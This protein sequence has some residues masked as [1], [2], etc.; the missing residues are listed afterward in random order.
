MEQNVEREEQRKI[1][2]KRK[3]RMGGKGREGK[4]TDV[5]N[6]GQRREWAEERK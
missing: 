2:K 1:K 4:G 3:G 5:S 6:E